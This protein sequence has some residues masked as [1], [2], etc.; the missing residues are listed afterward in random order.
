LKRIQIQ[1]L[2]L[3]GVENFT[4]VEKVMNASE[5]IRLLPLDQNATQNYFSLCDAAE[6][7]EKIERV[8]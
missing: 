3:C 1:I 7:G 2:I 6:T 5:A 8:P 4:S